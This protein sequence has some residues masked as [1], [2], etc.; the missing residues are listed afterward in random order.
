M[1]QTPKSQPYVN[2]QSTNSIN[3]DQQSAI[4]QSVPHHDESKNQWSTIVILCWTVCKLIAT[5][6]YFIAIIVFFS[7]GGVQIDY[8]LK[9]TYTFDDL[10]QARHTAYNVCNEFNCIS[11]S[12]GNITC[13]EFNA[14]IER[15]SQDMYSQISTIACY[16]CVQNGTFPQCS[17]KFQ[18]AWGDYRDIQSHSA[19]D[20]KQRYNLGVGLVVSAAAMTI[21][22]NVSFFLYLLYKSSL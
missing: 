11:L 4:V 18:S 14:Q 13:D 19:S 22:F 10:N 21:T 6:T 20:G 17:S 5:L 8:G 2:C 1:D 15:V 7:Y 9:H 3:V 12:Y 16:P